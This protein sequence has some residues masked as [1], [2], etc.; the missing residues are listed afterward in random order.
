MGHFYWITY[1]SSREASNGS[2]DEYKLLLWMVVWM[3]VEDRHGV[4]RIQGPLLQQ[5]I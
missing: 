3:R 5:L 1:V 4:Q 2:W